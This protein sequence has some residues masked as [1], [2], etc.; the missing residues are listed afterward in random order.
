[1]SLEFLTESFRN[2]IRNKKRK[3]NN[4]ERLLKEGDKDK[5]GKSLKRVKSGIHDKAKRIYRGAESNNKEATL[6]STPVPNSLKGQKNQL[7]QARHWMKKFADLRNRS[8]AEERECNRIIKN[9]NRPYKEPSQR[10]RMR[11]LLGLAD[12][13]D[14]NG[15]K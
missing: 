9:L 6:F 5:A 8:L 14:R 15:R 11:N 10:Q 12:L 2:F 1:M 4:I 7:K 3:L 13:A